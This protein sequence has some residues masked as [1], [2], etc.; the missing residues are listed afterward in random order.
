MLAKEQKYI[1]KVPGYVTEVRPAR[2]V[3]RWRQRTHFVCRFAGSALQ[4]RG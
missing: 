3:R 1:K 4:L 2:C